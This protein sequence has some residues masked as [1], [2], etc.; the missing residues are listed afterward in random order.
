[1]ENLEITAKTVDEA[2][3]K[4]QDI[5]NVTADRLEVTVVSEGKSG[6]WGI[7]AAEAR[8]RVKIKDLPSEDCD[9]S[10]QVARSVVQE[11]LDKTGIKAE[12]QTYQLDSTLGDEPHSI[13][14]NL[15]GSDMSSLIGRRGQT[16]DAFQYLV[17]LILT[18]RTHTKVPVMIDVENYKQRR[19]ES[20]K[21]LALNV[22]DQVRARKSSIRLEPMP[23]YERRIIHLTLADDPDVATE[24]MGEG[25]YRKVV[26]FPQNKK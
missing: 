20:L 18:K 13:V 21:T 11:L 10:L 2:I 25:E 14:L 9:E 22:A 19:F 26:V 12:I 1:M 3:R 6:I 7:G 4:A 16:I 5:H 17:R 8:I 15:T 23:A 24:S